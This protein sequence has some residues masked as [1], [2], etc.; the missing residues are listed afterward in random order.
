MEVQ[1]DLEWGRGNEQLVN[2]NLF[3]NNMKSDNQTWNC[4]FMVPVVS[5][6]LGVSELVNV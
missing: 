3:Y 4:V 1:F 5:L 2:S 6:K